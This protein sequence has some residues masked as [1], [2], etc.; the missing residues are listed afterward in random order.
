MDAAQPFQYKKHFVARQ[1]DRHARGRFRPLDVLEP[2]ELS[3]E[4]IPVQEQH[5]TLGE[6]LSCGRDVTINREMRKP[7][8]DL[9]GTIASG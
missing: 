3:L 8:L 4:D 2:R 7:G 5:G 1:H 6:V 9:G